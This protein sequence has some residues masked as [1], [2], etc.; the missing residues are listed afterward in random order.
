M[1][2]ITCVKGVRANLIDESAKEAYALN[3]YDLYALQSILELKNKMDCKITCLSMG[4]EAIRDTLIRCYALGADDVLWLRDSAFAGADTVAT[5]RALSQAI[6]HVGNYDLIVCGD[7]AIDGETGQVPGGIAQKLQIPY[8][9]GVEEIVEVADRTVT[10]RTLN[11]DHEQIVKVQLP[12]LITYNQ[13]T[14]VAHT[15]SLLSLKR[16]RKR[17]PI[18]LKAADIGLDKAMCGLQGSKTKVLHIASNMVKKNGEMLHKEG[19]RAAKIIHE[20][21][22]GKVE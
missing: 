13:F 2:I 15:I 6:A 18:I 5:S 16:A 11:E 22:L 20:L 4:S 12:A 1:E 17:E 19:V 7:V 3:P 14:T 8:I 9:A 10:L 21:I